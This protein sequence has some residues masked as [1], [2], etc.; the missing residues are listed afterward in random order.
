MTADEKQDLILKKMKES[1]KPQYVKIIRP[2]DRLIEGNVYEI[3][4]CVRNGMILEVFVFI[5]VE[6]DDYLIEIYPD[7]Y[8]ILTWVWCGS[9]PQ[10]EE[11]D[12]WKTIV[13]RRVN[14][15]AKTR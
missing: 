1:Y 3:C 7:E 15:K 10:P 2:V 4:R 13:R 8:E 14:G 12:K 11:R 6:G 5:T 9:I